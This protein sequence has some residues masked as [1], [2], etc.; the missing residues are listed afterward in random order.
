MILTYQFWHKFLQLTRC[1]IDASPSIT[2]SWALTCI[3][4]YMNVKIARNFATDG[5]L[6]FRARFQCSTTEPWHN[7][8]IRYKII[9]EGI[10]D[11]G[12]V[13]TWSTTFSILTGPLK[14]TSSFCNRLSIFSLRL[15]WR[16]RSSLNSISSPCISA[17]L[18]KQKTTAFNLSLNL[19]YKTYGNISFTLPRPFFWLILNLSGLKKSLPRKKQTNNSNFKIKY[20]HLCL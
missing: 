1:I 6:T 18:K 14:S 2:S 16:C 12:T 15:S 20:C 5:I 3:I 13:L 10:W 8:V 9:G 7:N 11:T 4:A 19:L 17:T